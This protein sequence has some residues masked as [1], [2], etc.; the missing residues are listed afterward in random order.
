MLLLLVLS[1][2]MGKSYSF[3]FYFC[4][5]HMATCVLLVLLCCSLWHAS[6][7][8]KSRWE[9]CCAPCISITHVWAF[10][11]FFSFV[12]VFKQVFDILKGAII[13]NFKDEHLLKG[14]DL[15]KTLIQDCSSV[16]QMILDTVKNRS[17]HESFTEKHQK[18][19]KM[20]F[21]LLQIYAL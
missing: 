14:S 16:A 7:V 17:E 4:R 11:F 3:N 10:V 5:H 21:F 12:S 9:M 20:F 8:M 2:G 6:S 19:C 18:C 13:K 15:V 1:Y